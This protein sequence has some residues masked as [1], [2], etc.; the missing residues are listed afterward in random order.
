MW[1]GASW[2]V[3]NDILY[4]GDSMG[5]TAAVAADTTGNLFITWK[6]GGQIFFSRADAQMAWKASSWSKPVPVSGPGWSL[7]SK[8]AVDSAQRVYVVWDESNDI[9]DPDGAGEIY[10][11]RSD[12]DGL[13]WS[14]PTNISRSPSFASK[15][16]VLAIDDQD[17]L[18]VA[19]GDAWGEP[20][21]GGADLAQEVYY[22]RSS[23]AGQSWLDP[24]CISSSAEPS[25]MP[26]V[27]TDAR[28]NACVLWV[29]SPTA[30]QRLLGS[31]NIRCWTGAS[32]SEARQVPDAAVEASWPSLA[33]DSG[34]TLH[35]VWAEGKG[36]D[37]FP[38]NDVYYA[39]SHDRGVSWSERVNL[40]NTS[41]GSHRPVV[42]V[43]EGNTV[44]VFWYD[45]VG[46][47]GH[48]EG[49]D[50]DIYYTMRRVD[51][52]FQPPS[53]ARIPETL[54][55]TPVASFVPV[56]ATEAPPAGLL[57]G[58]TTAPAA[59]AQLVPPSGDFVPEGQ[60]PMA[61]LVM[62]VTGVAALLGLVLF[63]KLRGVM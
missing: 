8:I 34:D 32:W 25:G 15:R 55:V 56:S 5:Q 31:L 40:S 33:V 44:H 29:E 49:G 39:Y 54:L 50:W 4:L 41:K 45:G 37:V 1:D 11:R 7:F 60:Q 48:G 3:A 28:G 52:P 46:L 62:A 18:H 57:A 12:D 42:A 2:S 17:Q 14:L 9:G 61:S 59:T 36:K 35:V 16:A 24:V 51:A 10:V 19:W 30:T 63:V 38:G 27:V 47:G 43:S 53:L 6:G 22:S 26:G 21:A 20:S 23:D 13:N 58:G